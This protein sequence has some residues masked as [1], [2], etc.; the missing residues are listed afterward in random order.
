MDGSGSPRPPLAAGN[1]PQGTL[2]SEGPLGWMCRSE[3]EWERI[4]CAGRAAE[5]GGNPRGGRPR[6]EG[7]CGE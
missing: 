4:L 3:G 7:R 6:G 2:L 5:Q 1:T